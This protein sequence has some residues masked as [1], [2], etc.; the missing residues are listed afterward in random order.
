[1]TEVIPIRSEADAIALIEQHID[2]TLPEGAQISFDGWPNLVIKLEGDKFD[3]SLTPSVMKGF[4][5]LQRAIH[6][7]YAATRYDD[8]SRRLSD[9]EKQALEFTVKVEQGSSIV[10]VNLQEPV[11]RILQD[12]VG[13]MDPNS[14]LIAAVTLATLFVGKSLLGKY[15]DNQRQDKAER[16]RNERDRVML[17]NMQIMSAEET[18]RAQ[19]IAGLVESN[20]Q[21]INVS[22]IA[23]DARTELVRSMSSADQ[24]EISGI[25][26]DGDMAATLTRNAREM[27]SEIRIDGLYKILR[28]DASDPSVF[29]VK[30]A[31]METRR[32]IEAIVQDD[33]MNS[34]NK[35]ALQQAEWAR[36]PVRLEI[37]AKLLRDRVHKAVILRVSPVDATSDVESPH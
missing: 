35:R 9:E 15:L 30:V 21:L 17:E 2:G 1:M 16:A 36:R 37:N 6:R 33:S 26:M 23:H 24:V 32:E 25:V 10:E 27:S 19:V 12:L 3:Q 28:V 11:L 29:K 22:R 14:A 8:P 20:H 4:V 13:K 34:D 31:H 7:S 5:E 18:R